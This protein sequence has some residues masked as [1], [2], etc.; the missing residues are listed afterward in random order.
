MHWLRPLIQ[1]ILVTLALGTLAAFAR[2]GTQPCKCKCYG[3]E[4]VVTNPY[5]ASVKLHVKCGKRRWTQRLPAKG[6]VVM[7]MHAG[8]CEIR[9]EVSFF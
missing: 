9:P 5:R 3:C 2:S 7:M 8:R 6:S 1:V 4:A